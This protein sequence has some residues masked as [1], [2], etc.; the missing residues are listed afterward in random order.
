MNSIF[1]SALTPLY[2]CFGSH[3]RK[4]VQKYISKGVQC[5]LIMLDMQF[6]PLLYPILKCFLEASIK[7]GREVL[8]SVSKMPQ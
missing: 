8:Y 3:V 4:L 7:T 6:S 2:L 1:C 5:L